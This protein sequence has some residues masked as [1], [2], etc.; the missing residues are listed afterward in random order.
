MNIGTVL[1][2][3]SDMPTFVLRGDVLDLLVVLGRA[4]EGE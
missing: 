1:W 2:A 4:G 3:A